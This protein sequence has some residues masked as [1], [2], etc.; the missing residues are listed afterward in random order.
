L[1]IIPPNSRA[2]AP[3]LDCKVIKQ[4]LPFNSLVKMEVPTTTL[5][6]FPKE[7]TTLR[8]GW[9]AWEKLVLDSLEAATA[10]KHGILGF[11]VD[12]AR[13]VQIAGATAVHKPV[14]DPGELPPDATQGVT[15]VHK[16]NMDQFEKQQ[17]AVK[18][19]KT[20]ILACL[21]EE[22]MDVVTHE[23]TGTRDRSIQQILD[24]LRENYGTLSVAEIEHQKNKLKAPYPIN[25]PIRNYLR[26]H[27][28]VH[29]VLMTASQPMSMA[30]KVRELRASVKHATHLGTAV[31]HFL[32]TNPTLDGQTFDKLARLLAEAEDN[33]EP[34]PTTGS[35]GYAAAATSEPTMVSMDTVQQMIAAAVAKALSANPRKEHEGKSVPKRAAL[36][37]KYCWTHGPCAH[38]SADCNRPKEGHMW[39]A[40]DTNRQGGA[41]TRFSTMHRGAGKM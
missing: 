25:T 10:H 30:D 14:D 7:G 24:L 12:A 20:Q 3:S 1:I 37:K 32:T 5:T 19:A 41:T 34:Q 16:F 40:T 26:V 36:P 29:K 22:A 13:L 31:Q 21:N 6:P 28:E 18:K 2:T 4:F 23:A 9:P 8:A 11:G 15:A 17:L 35:A 27:R 39:D 38:A 33:G